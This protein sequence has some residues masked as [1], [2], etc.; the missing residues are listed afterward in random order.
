MAIVN[1]S[2]REQEWRD[3]LARWRRS[4]QTVREF[5]QRERLSVSLF[6]YWKKEVARRDLGL[7]PMAC[8]GKPKPA[9]TRRA[10]KFVPL[11]VL[12]VDL[13]EATLEVVLAGGRRLKIGG[14]F[15]A[16]VLKKLL[17]VL[18]PTA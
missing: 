10:A 12:R 18:E 6:Y 1:R 2:P 11:N 8:N 3:T 4:G 15:N 5:C 16:A 13:D 17:G 9:R 14:D 7:P